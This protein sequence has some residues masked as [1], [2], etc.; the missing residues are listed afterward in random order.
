MCKNVKTVTWESEALMGTPK[1]SRWA[2]LCP[3]AALSH[4]GLFVALMLYTGGGGLVFQALEYPAELAKQ[5]FHRD[6]L[7]TERW[8]L[9]R[10]VSEQNANITDEQTLQK[11]L[12]DHLAVYERVLE[13]A[14]SSGLSLEIDLN[15]PAAEEKWSILQAVF[16]S[17]TVLTTIGYGNIVPETF[18]GRLFCIAYALVGI[19]LTLTVIADLGRVFATVVSVI[20]K[21]L[22]EMPRCCSK[23][24]D[25]NPAGQRSLYALWAVGF[26]F[27]YL[28]AGA[29]LFKMWED[30]WTFYDGFYFCFITMTTI[31]FGD[32]V[33][34]RPKYMLLCTL[35]ILIG[36]ALTSTIIE[37]VRR[38]YARS[39]QQ[40]RALSGPLADTLRRLGDAGRGVDVSA[41]HND[42]RKVLTV[43]TMP[44]LSG[45]RDAL[46]DKRQ[47]EW[48]AAVEAV[49]RDITAPVN[50][51]KPP[52][53]QIV[54]Y[55]SSV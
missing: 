43:V 28:S 44:R 47:L 35:Y 34:K 49:I 20:A 30:D 25:A 51:K 3:R 11:S 19:P 8:N 48:E 46:S 45:G 31:G 22:P 23:V 10:F 7:L 9:I 32:L 21:H 16:F 27:L 2:Q 1:E 53:V 6:R 40:L 14:S 26:L 17:S 37:L 12:S 52:I 4:V 24:T 15:F 18:W 41:L 33:P 50:Q 5:E 36:L 54:I 13:Q 38:Q 55:E 42:L 29:G 39:W